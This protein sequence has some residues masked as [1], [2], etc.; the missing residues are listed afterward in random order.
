[1]R[2]EVDEA[3]ALTDATSAALSGIKDHA[4]RVTALLNG[5]ASSLSDLGAAATTADVFKT[6][7]RQLSAEFERVAIFKVK[8]KHLIG[9]LAAGL[10]KSL[11]IK[12]IVIPAGG[13]IVLPKGGARARAPNAPRGKK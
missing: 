6:L 9:D 2:A 8:E 1:M 4:R 7:V 12:K 13:G 10:D 3:N 5:A 11:D